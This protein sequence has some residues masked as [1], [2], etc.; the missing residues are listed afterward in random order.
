[1]GRA[2]GGRVGGR[3]G[4]TAFI[5]SLT[6]AYVEQA[7]SRAPGATTL[8]DRAAPPVSGPSVRYRD[9]YRGR[10][11]VRLLVLAALAIGSLAWLGSVALRGEGPLGSTFV[12]LGLAEPPSVVVPST[13]TSVTSAEGKFSVELPLGASEHSEPVD[14][15]DPGRG[16]LHGFE[17]ELG[18]EGSIAVLSSDMGMGATLRHLDDAGF[19]SLVDHFVAGSRFGIETVR[20]DVLIGVGRVKDSVIASH[21]GTGAT[22]VRFAL[23]DDRLHVLAT[24]GPDEHSRELDAAHARLIDTF[25][26]TT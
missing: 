22:R 8:L 21:D 23:V 10:R 2:R 7:A 20:R 25:A 5:L 11:A 14:P 12:S 26:P 1:M 9:P 19:S 16:T 4:V 6:S 24:S 17:A 15:D 18:D 3:H 13:W